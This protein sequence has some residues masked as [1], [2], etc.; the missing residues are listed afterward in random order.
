MNIKAWAVPGAESTNGDAG[1]DIAPGGNPVIATL[2]G[3]RKPFCPTTEITT[4]GLM[5]PTVMEIV[6]GLRENLKSGCGGGLDE[7]SPLQPA[8]RNAATNTGQDSAKSFLEMLNLIVSRFHFYLPNQRL[9]S[10]SPLSS[11]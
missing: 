1:D 11:R 7:P 9:I 6:E 2:T 5:V 3:A 8:V 4:C 10:T